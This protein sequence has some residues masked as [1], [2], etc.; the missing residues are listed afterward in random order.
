M[1]LLGKTAKHVGFGPNHKI[2][3]DPQIQG[4]NSGLGWSWV[5]TAAGVLYGLGGYTTVVEMSN[6]S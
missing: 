3:A 5:L 1:E 4:G 6:H 2:C